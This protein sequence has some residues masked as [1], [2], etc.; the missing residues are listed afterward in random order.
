M[1]ACLLTANIVAAVRKLLRGSMAPNSR[2]KKYSDFKIFFRRSKPIFRA[3][4]KVDTHSHDL[5]RTYSFYSVPGGRIGGQEERLVQ[6]FFGNRPFDSTTQFV[7]DD[8]SGIPSR[9]LRLL[10]ESGALLQYYREPSGAVTC[11]LMPAQVE[12]VRGREDFIVLDRISSPLRLLDRSVTRRH[13]RY[14][15][16]YM[17]C[18]CID[19]DPNLMDRARTAW[20]RFTK[21]RVVKN[22]QAGTVLE[23]WFWK[24]AS[25]ALTV[26]LSGFLLLLLPKA[27]TPDVSK[28]QVIEEAPDTTRARNAEAKRL[29][30]IAATISTM[31]RDIHALKSLT[32]APIAV[33]VIELPEKPKDTDTSPPPAKP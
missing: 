26:G 20:I 1:P 14:F 30:D 2:Q 21:V 22:A 28:V 7:S 29:D 5:S 33:K 32:S 27:P 16:S 4:E 3:Y 19:G 15:I 23:K 9:Q 24:S 18:T 13:W 6:I 17:H 11:L 31:S 10:T 25:F 12:N 8:K